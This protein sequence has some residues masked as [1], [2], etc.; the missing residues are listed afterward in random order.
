MSLHESLRRID[1][2]REL[3]GFRTEPQQMRAAGP[4]KIGALRLGFSMRGGR[5]VLS[6]LYR[7]TPLL[8]QQALYWD[9]AMPEL[10]ICSIISIGGG[11]LQGDRYTIDIS[12]G[13]GAC[14][15]VTSQG[16]N[17]IHQMDANYASQHQTVTLAKDAYLEFLP[18]FTI[19]YRDS[20]FINDTDLVVHEDAT[21]LY[22]EM[23]MTGRKHH[24]ASERFGF[25]LLS[26][27]V[28]ARRPDGRKLFTE[29]VLIEKGNETI[30]FPA[31]M[32]GYDAFANILCITPPA[33]AE[34]IRERV[35]VNFGDERPRAISG[36]S[37]LPNGA[38]L[39]LR[40]VGVESYDVR[41]EVRNF[42]K[43]VRE[44]AR[45]KTLPEEFLWR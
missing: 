22:G 21:L 37:T 23:M 7:V 1:E 36:V 40:V 16:A 25:D 13:E 34:R 32:G 45:G 28:N 11:I 17:R 4:G 20:R 19:P 35:N 2:Y 14:A 24:H 29:K 41:A 3:N 8:V 43:V 31:V 38:G 6:D 33:V 42:W 5:S 15:Q 9:E 30:D 18:D 44:E 10:P 12:V 27:T 39:M 26:M